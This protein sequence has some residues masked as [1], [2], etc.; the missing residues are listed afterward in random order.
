V[1]CQRLWARWETTSLSTNIIVVLHSRAATRRIWPLLTVAA[2]T[3]LAIALA[4]AG[5]SRAGNFLV[6]NNAR[7]SDLLVVLGGDDG[8]RLPKAIQ[9]MQGGLAS[10]VIVDADAAHRWLG[11]TGADRSSLLIA[12]MPAV[13]AHVRVCPVLATSTVGETRDLYGC[14]QHL[15]VSR[16]VL[17]TSAY[18]TRR[19]LSTFRH[20]LPQYEWSVASAENSDVFGTSWWRRRAWVTT[21]FYEWE[22]LLWREAVERWTV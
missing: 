5:M 2:L 6:V 14:I 3:V 9:L 16:I 22:K 10:E 4:V 13:A 17:V 21:T 1:D 18:H 19:A 12:S 7:P 15:H 8:S 11:R 20:A